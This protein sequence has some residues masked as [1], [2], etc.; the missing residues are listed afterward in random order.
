M[1]E[2][3]PDARNG[4]DASRPPNQDDP[5]GWFERLYSDA[6]AGQ[7]VVPWDRG[8]PRQLLVEWG[9]AR[10]LNGAGRRAVVVG[11]GLGYDAEH[12]AG[13]GFETIA[14]DIAPTAIRVARRRSPGSAVRYLVADLLDPPEE[15]REAFDLVVESHNVQALPDPPRREAIGRV[16]SM[17]APGGTL[18]VL[19]AARDAED[20]PVEGPPWPLIRTEIEA[21]AAG[22]LETVRI[23]DLPD[24]A[25][26]EVRRWRAEFRRP[27]RAGE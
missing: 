25:E 3:D 12:I 9:E 21:F 20:G 19:A 4:A 14:F 17:V 23:E 8:A 24:P 16:S 22:I 2:R 11:C 18:I 13:L 27:P 7:A 6:E 15:W 26:P 5:T 1:T 10:S